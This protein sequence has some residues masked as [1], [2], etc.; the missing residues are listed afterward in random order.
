MRK[1]LI[2]AALVACFKPIGAQLEL[3]AKGL[4]SGQIVEISDSF[5]YRLDSVYTYIVQNDMWSLVG[6]ES[7]VYNDE[8]DLINSQVQTK[9][10]NNWQDAT[11]LQYI[12]TNE[13]VVQ[14]LEQRWDESN[15]T[16][17]NTW[18][19]YYDNNPVNGQLSIRYAEWKDNAWQNVWQQKQLYSSAGHF[20]AY[21]TDYWDAG[22]NSWISYWK[23]DRVYDEN[24]K[25]VEVVNQSFDAD[26]RLWKDE[27]QVLQTYDASGKLL[28]Q[29]IIDR[30]ESNQQWENVRLVEINNA[31]PNIRIEVRE[32]WD[33]ALDDWAPSVRQSDELGNNGQ[34]LER[35][36]E[37]WDAILSD[38]LPYKRIVLGYN[39]DG[40]KTE[41]SI[42][43]YNSQTEDYD[44]YLK[45][46]YHYQPMTASGEDV[47]E[48]EDFGL[49][50]Y[51]NPA[52]NYLIMNYK[53]EAR[54]LAICSMDG[55][56]VHTQ[57]VMASGRSIDVSRLKAGVYILLVKFEG[58]ESTV[59]FIKK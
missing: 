26:T 43:Y 21:N 45:T 25:L 17:K 59:K 37:Q 4:G 3:Q 30:D 20:Q 27:W 19:K 49:S 44:K 35:N 47:K 28:R 58:G 56:V 46:V 33:V 36:L 24:G 2:V 11:R 7:F 14:Q 42:Y 34:L 1:I 23:Y 22:T 6:C 16:W 32:N 8:K 55:K 12:Y 41:E 10:L 13:N 29:E 51:P 31:Q 38:W 52:E 40:I 18:T 57:E 9:A 15:D 48:Q 5:Y 54:E 53:G 50:V 39:K